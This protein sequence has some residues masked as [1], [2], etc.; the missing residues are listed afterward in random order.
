MSKFAI[1]F[2]VVAG[3]VLLL[4]PH[5]WW[6]SFYD[7]PYMGIAALVCAVLIWRAPSQFKTPLAIILLL[8]ASGDLGLYEL[9][10]YGFQYDKVIHFVS[11]LIATL[12]LG[13]ALGIRRSVLIV[14]AAGFAWELFEFLM[15]HYFKTRLFGVYRLF[16]WQDTIMD[17]VFN[18]IGVSVAVAI[19]LFPKEPQTSR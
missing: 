7:L 18:T 8:N 14:I 15:D 19:A 4:T 6:P 2:F 3:L 1:T 13:R 9:Y 10:R 5:A 17:L 11:A 12:T 16:I